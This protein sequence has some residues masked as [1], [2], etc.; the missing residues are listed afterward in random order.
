MTSLQSPDLHLS[1]SKSHKHSFYPELHS[2]AAPQQPSHLTLLFIAHAVCTGAGALHLGSRSCHLFG[3]ENI[4]PLWPFSGGSVG[5]KTITSAP[6]LPHGSAAPTCRESRPNDLASTLFLGVAVPS[7]ISTHPLAS[8]GHYVKK[9][10]TSLNQ[11]E[12]RGPRGVTLITNL[13]KKC[14]SPSKQYL[15]S[16]RIWITMS[17]TTQRNNYCG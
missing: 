10:Q 12:S 14:Y 3:G 6:L 16:R 15:F 5:F 13:H 1:S 2:F 7:T 9:Q 8:L 11:G 17:L 4:I